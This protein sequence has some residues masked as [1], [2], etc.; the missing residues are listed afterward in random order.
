M[1]I[2]SSVGLIRR[3]GDTRVPRK[4]HS[5]HPALVRLRVAATSMGGSRTCAGIAILV[6]LLSVVAFV[7][8]SDM[9]LPKNQGFLSSACVC[10]D[11]ASQKTGYWGDDEGEGEGEDAS[12]WRWGCVDAA[13]QRGAGSA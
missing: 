9:Q 11:A 2:P 8:L 1:G 5:E 10:V 7:C 4:P 13:S 3:L 12:E 6:S